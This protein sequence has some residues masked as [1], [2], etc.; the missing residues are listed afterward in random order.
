MR[1]LI[2]ISIS[3][4]IDQFCILTFQVTMA[5]QITQ[6]TF[7]DVV[8]ENISEFDMNPEEAVQDAIQQFESQVSVIS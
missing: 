1:M 7:D 5:K 8:R 3:K 2:L 6:S 4:Y